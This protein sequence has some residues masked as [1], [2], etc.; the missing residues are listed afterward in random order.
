[1]NKQDKQLLLQD[2]C[3]RLPYDTIVS[4][5]NVNGRL[6]EDVKLSPYH[7]AA[8]N[9][10]DIKAYLRPMSSMTEE[11]KKEFDNDF[12]VINE[13]AWNGNTEV[14]FKNQSI[15]MSDAIDWLN[16]HYIDFRGLIEKGLALP[17]PEGMYN[18]DNN[19]NTVNT[20]INN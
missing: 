15:I 7:L 11:E 12:M 4:V 3:A 8:F 1:M 6:R 14:G 20:S 18:N 16:A 10:W 2:L 9:I 5:R 19:E 13:D 17:A